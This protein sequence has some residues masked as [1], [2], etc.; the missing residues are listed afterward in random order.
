MGKRVFVVANELCSGCRNC[1]MWCSFCKRQNEFNPNF[2]KIKIL[3]N[4]EGLLNVPTVDCDG[5]G[6]VLN[7][8]E[9]PICVEMCPTGTLVF[10]DIEDLY[11]K[12]LEL[13]EKRKIQPVF[14]LIAS[15]KYP[16]P[17]KEW[18]KEEF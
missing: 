9:E 16:Y 5:E 14:R 3:K 15:W 7:E 10:T 18:S 4:P 2:P 11:R 1:E 17:W 13:D 12:R 8:R 6:C